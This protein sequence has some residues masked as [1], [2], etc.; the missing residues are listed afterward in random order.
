MT[1][2]N[3]LFF[4]SHAR[5]PGS[6][7]D[8]ADPDQPV[9]D[10]YEDLRQ[11]VARVTGTTGPGQG[12]IDRRD[13]PAD[14]WLSAL[15]ASRVFVPLYAPRYFSDPVCGRQWTAFARRAGASHVRTVVPV[16][17]IPPTAGSPLPLAIRGVQVHLPEERDPEGRQAQDRYTESGL[18]QLKEL[19]DD[20]RRAYHRI[21]T[22]LAERIARAAANPLTGPTDVEELSEGHALED[23]F[24]PQPSKP[25]LRIT[26]LAP[27]TSRLPPGREATRYGPEPGDWQPYGPTSGPLAQQA[28]AV[29]RNLGFAPDVVSFDKAEEILPAGSA[30]SGR[31]R[32]VAPWIVV[33]DAWVLGDLRTAE[34]VRSIDRA[35]HPWLAVLAVL[36]DD[37]PQTR[38]QER[39]LRDLLEATLS[40][41]RTLRGGRLTA[42][43]TAARGIPNADA[44]ALAFAEL[45]QSCYMRYLDDIQD[46]SPRSRANAG[47]SHGG[48]EAD[49]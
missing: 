41:H 11:E 47:R 23:A 18:F 13:T 42:R 25:E 39:R 1:D 10:F 21:V 32:P 29:A 34:A 48:S 38:Q 24:A 27:G 3:P 26:V 22:R 36:A 15:A 5:T 33:V 4:V 49:R 17:W 6:R 12:Y 35:D 40:R 7:Q 43:G 9:Y 20:D 30:A 19:E 28:V 37:D 8:A 46:N 44:F 14:G 16:L 2:R 45:A 31:H